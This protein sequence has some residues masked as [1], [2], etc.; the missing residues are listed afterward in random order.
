M[1]PQ[2]PYQPQSPPSPGGVPPVAPSNW[3]SPAPSQAPSYGTPSPAPT[4][5]GVDYLNQ[6]APQEQKKTNNFAVIALIAA[7]L[8]SALFGVILISSSGGPSADDQLPSIAARITTL[9]TVTEAQQPHLRETKI[10]EANAALGSALASMNTDIT[11]ILKER[12]LKSSD[13]STTAKKEKTYA[14][15]LA[16]TLDDSYQRGTLDTTYTSQMTYELSVL[17]TKLSKLK[18]TTKTES[19]TSFATNGITNIDTILKAYESAES[20]TTQ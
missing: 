14:G 10:T 5:Y 11:A 13:K 19:L 1:N 9:K 15:T 20:S 2:D 16:K 17:R 18:R 4:N 8:I 6:I 7:V 12:K 3:R